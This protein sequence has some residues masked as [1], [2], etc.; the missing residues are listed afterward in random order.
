MRAP[1]LL[2][3]LLFCAATGCATHTGPGAEGPGGGPRGVEAAA[4]PFKVL[5]AHGGQEVSWDQFMTEVAGADAVCIGEQHTN[6]HHHW[7]QLHIVD[8]LTMRART[9]GVTEALGMEMFQQPFQGVLDDF[10]AGRI[11]EGALLSRAGWGQRWNFDW[12]LYRPIVLM[13]RKRGAA[14][15]ALNASD[16]LRHELSKKGVAGMSPA[17]RAKLP[18]MNLDDHQHRAWFDAQMSAMGGAEAHQHQSDEKAGHA[19][20]DVDGDG[21]GDGDGGSGDQDKNGAADLDQGSGGADSSDAGEGDDS[22]NDS[23]KSGDPPGDGAE[24]PASGKSVM[25]RAYS[26]Q[27]LWDESMAQSAASWL[28]APDA[29]SHRRQVVI[30]A[31]TGHCHESAIVRRIERRGIKNAV[32]VHPVIDDGEGEVA[33]LLAAPENDYLFVM[34][35]PSE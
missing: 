30:L 1:A 12:S 29:G 20:G 21:D 3:A 15:L 6:P 25:D 32:S 9:T 16:E 14:L 13:A 27:V 31:G 24:D 7:A 28:R 35:M 26:V 34:T 22:D 19:G 17:E 23:D 8:A 4:L 18:D 33:E 10:D 5:R 2:A 11:D